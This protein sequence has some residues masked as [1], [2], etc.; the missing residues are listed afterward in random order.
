MKKTKLLATILTGAL[1]F[2]GCSDTAK[3]VVNKAP[4]LVG[5]K[6]FQ[7]IVNS[8]IDFLD[9]VAALDV[10]DGDITPKMEITITPDVSVKNGYAT[11][12]QVGEYAVNYL[13][14][15]S[16]GRTSKKRSYV[17]V[18]DRE[19]YH[20][21]IMP[22]G[23]S[24]VTQGN[25]VVDK[26][27]MINNEFVINA[28]GGEIAEDVKLVRTFT[29]KTNLEYTFK[30]KLTS[31]VGGKVKAFADG[32]ECAEA[33]VLNGENVLCFK[34][35]VWDD[36]EDQ[37][38]VEIAIC[39]G[40]L[41][42]VNWVVKG[43]ECEYPQNAGEFVELATDFNFAGR[44]V[45]RIDNDNGNNNLKGNAWSE[46]DGEAARLE[47]TDTC[48]DIWRGGMFINTEI[49]L[50]AGVT[51]TIG[52]DVD[53]FVS[54]SDA[55]ENGDFEV[56]IQ[57]GQ[58]NEYQFVKKYSPIGRVEEEITVSESTAGALWIY[59]QSGTA[60]NTI[61]L[62]NLSVKERLEP[63]GT[64][65]FEIQ[66]FS[67]FHNDKYDCIFTTDRGN[68]KYVVKNFS[69][70]D[71]EHTITSPVFFVSG[72]GSNYAITFTAKATAPIEMIIASPVAG[73]WDPTLMWNKV[74][75][76]TEET[77]YT[78]FGNG[79]ASNRNYTLVW[80]FGSMSNQAYEDVTIE[81]SNI[82]ISLKNNELD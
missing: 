69:N 46:N 32:D 16:E 47:I 5:I 17:D 9:G 30:Y 22:E 81:I 43:V 7:C 56:I 66:D 51:Y 12:T 35:T 79:N 15:D 49:P 54:E 52:F 19:A 4:T 82:K 6:D 40:A 3:T 68:F 78:F 75:L 59:V 44:V 27:G 72:S 8:T 37:K 55:E 71:N 36:G 76:S 77:V 23:F 60:K 38:Q 70:I 65:T 13:V 50:K 58:W 20:D 73:G 18:V 1:V 39:L 80:Q 11:F 63:V 53:R 34:H 61:T 26:C 29:L 62:S 33:L 64:D 41:G 67:E 28:S 48:A 2:A 10:E 42:D 25:A 31:D 74:T 14:T 57:R 45:P 21:F 24:V